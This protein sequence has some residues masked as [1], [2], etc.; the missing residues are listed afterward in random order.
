[1]VD[2]I[3]VHMELD[4]GGVRVSL[5]G[6][7]LV[8][9]DDNEPIEGQLQLLRDAVFSEMP[10]PMMLSHVTGVTYQ[11]DSIEMMDIMGHKHYYKLGEF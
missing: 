2:M 9:W 1:M 8:G 11:Q 10:L 3:K 6:Y 5:N 7:V 4:M